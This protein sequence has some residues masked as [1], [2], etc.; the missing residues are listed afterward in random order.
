MST[1]TITIYTRSYADRTLGKMFV[2]VNGQQVYSCACLELPWKDNA[3][4]ESCIPAGTYPIRLEY[5]NAFKMKLWEVHEVPGR[6][7]VKIH[8]ANYP[9]ELRGC[10]A[11]ASYLADIDKDGNMDGAA[12]RV[13]L[14]AVMDAMGVARESTLTVIALDDLR[15]L[16]PGMN[17]WR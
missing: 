6:S 14:R 4:G 15:K 9:R 3:T 13:A 2:K 1:P 8:A 17:G 7:E 11:P 16:A 10:I 12:S 5:S